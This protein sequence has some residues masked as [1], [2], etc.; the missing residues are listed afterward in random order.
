MQH[1]EENSPFYGKLETAESFAEYCKAVGVKD[2]LYW[3][4]IYM[5]IGLDYTPESPQ[6]N[7]PV[8]L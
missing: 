2:P 7:A 5:R 8:F 4:K 3:Q 1:R 6:G